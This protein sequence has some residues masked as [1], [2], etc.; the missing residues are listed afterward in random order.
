MVFVLLL[1]ELELLMPAVDF[2]LQR[3]AVVNARLAYCRSL[4]LNDALAFYRH[5]LTIL[6][7]LEA[8]TGLGFRYLYAK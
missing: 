4:H 5:L 3:I 1:L 6:D 2:L 7:N 8:P